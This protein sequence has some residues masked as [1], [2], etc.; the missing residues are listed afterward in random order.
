MIVQWGGGKLGGPVPDAKL[1]AEIELKRQQMI[2]SGLENGLQ[3][4]KTLELSKQ[5][6]HLMNV[7]EH[8]QNINSKYDWW[9]KIICKLMF[10]NPLVGEY[11]FWTQQHSHFPL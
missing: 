9:M 4:V 11:Y 7:F 1:L 3:S 6:D 8:S 5:V 2:Q 10:R